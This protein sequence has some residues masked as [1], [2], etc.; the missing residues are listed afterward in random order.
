MT[1]VTTTYDSF[2]TWLVKQK[3]GNFYSFKLS[4]KATKIEMS[5]REGFISLGN[6]IF[7]AEKIDLLYVYNGNDLLYE[8]RA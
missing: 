1:L 3:S 7:V 8:K 6:V 2:C 5:G 4:N